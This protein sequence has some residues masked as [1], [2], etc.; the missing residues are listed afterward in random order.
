MQDLSTTIGRIVYAAVMIVFGLMHFMAGSDMAGMVPI[1]PEVFWIY[2]TGA[3]LIAAGIAM[4]LQKMAKLASMLL[5]LMLLIFA[6]TLHFPGV[7]DGD[8]HAMPSFLKD[9]ALAAAAFFFSGY[10]AEQEGQPSENA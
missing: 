1:P 3:A 5:A 6:F 4:I 7:L 10:F 8:Q 2:F 9:L